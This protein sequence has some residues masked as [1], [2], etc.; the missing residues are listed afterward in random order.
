[1][2]FE[3]ITH[4]I[5]RKENEKAT[6]PSDKNND[7]LQY[8]P[9]CKDST[10]R[11]NASRF[12]KFCSWTQKTPDKLIEEY[13]IAKTLNN[14]DDWE[15][16]T[17]NRIIKFYQLLL[18]QPNPNNNGKP[19]SSNYCNTVGSAVLAFYH[20]NCREIEG[21][22]DAF[23]PTQMPKDEYRFS[24]DDLRKMFHFGDTEEK[25]LISLAVSYGQG[26]KD[27]LKLEA[28]KLRDVINEARDKNRDFAMWISE[29]R[30]KSGI[31]PASFLTPEAIESVDA[32]L[33][34]L[35]NRRARA[36]NRREKLPKF[37]W[38]S[39]KPNKHIRIQV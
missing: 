38:C 21:V 10:K 15:R 24:Q 14:L 5:E 17:A 23:A 29:G 1:L 4:K 2:D 28:Q 18:K 3:S 25:A 22:M 30:Q 19:Y 35:E 36:E 7:Y 20:Q 16:N 8:F 32:Y 6:M 9:R 31:S 39:S 13:E 33:Q 27:F 34:L 26:S 12:K 37:I 11:G